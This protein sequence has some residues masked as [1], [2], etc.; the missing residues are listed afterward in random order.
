MALT[1]QRNELGLAYFGQ[2]TIRFYFEKGCKEVVDDELHKF[3]EYSSLRAEGDGRYKVIPNDAKHHLVMI[4]L[5]RGVVVFHYTA[6]DGRDQIEDKIEM[7]KTSLSKRLEV[8][9]D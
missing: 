2:D 7:F 6:P 9:Q 8:I 1:L 5:S 4:D 3:G